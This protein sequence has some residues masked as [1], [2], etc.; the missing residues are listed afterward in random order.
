[1]ELV[2]DIDNLLDAIDKEISLLNQVTKR[3]NLDLD[4]HATQDMARWLDKWE[5]FL[6]LEDGSKKPAPAKGRPHS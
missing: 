5:P 4:S 1:M 6:L 3:M 2:R